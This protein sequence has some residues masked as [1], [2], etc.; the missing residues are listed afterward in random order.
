MLHLASSAETDEPYVQKHCAEMT[1]RYQ[2]RQTVF[3]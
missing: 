3:G 2:R 1:R